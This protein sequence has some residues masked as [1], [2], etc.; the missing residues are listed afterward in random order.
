MDIL[1]CRV[2]VLT[3]N[4]HSGM[5]ASGAYSLERLAFEIRASGCDVACL[6]EVE[7][8]EAGNRQR[9]RKW[10][11]EHADEQ[12]AVLSQ[13]SGLAHWA[14]APAMARV[15][16]AASCKLRSGSLLS[17]LMDEQF[18]E[19]CA[20]YGI[21]ILSRFPIVRSRQ[22]QFHESSDQPRNAQ[23]V[24]LSIH[25]EGNLQL[26]IVNTHLSSKCSPAP[27]A[28]RSC[29]WTNAMHNAFARLFSLR[30]HG[31]LA[32]EAPLCRWCS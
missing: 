6:Q 32:F 26:W 10:S 4:I 31:G 18:E 14:F 20:D 25:A 23:A 29:S 19:G 3:F 11:A 30:G 27:S 2:R 15:R 1:P 7:S 22:L 21:A 13:L 8:I 17:E 12:P 24:L 16:L 9:T 5:G 28:L